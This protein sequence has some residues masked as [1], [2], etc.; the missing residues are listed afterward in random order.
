MR[1]L[2]VPGI[3]TGGNANNRL[4]YSRIL[5]GSSEG[6]RG[7]ESRVGNSRCLQAR[8]RISWHQPPR[9]LAPDRITRI[10]DPIHNPEMNLGMTQLT[11][12]LLCCIGK[13][14]ALWVLTYRSDTRSQHG[15]AD[16]S[17]VD[18]RGKFPSFASI[19]SIILPFAGT[20]GNHRHL[21]L[22]SKCL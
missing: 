11:M 4:L 10:P 18:S 7:E 17:S 1:S 8:A 3:C 6:W 20:P 9:F 22:T 12:R 14:V 21:R 5:R 15:Q 19:S 13:P 2:Q 16:T